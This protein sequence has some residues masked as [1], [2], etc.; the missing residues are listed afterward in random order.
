TNYTRLRV[1]ARFDDGTAVFFNCV[2]ILDD[3]NESIFDAAINL[4]TSQD[5]F[6]RNIRWQ[7]VS[8]QLTVGERQKNYRWKWN[9]ATM[10][11]APLKKEAARRLFNGVVKGESVAVR[12]FGET[13][14]GQPLPAPNP[15]FTEF[16]KSCPALSGS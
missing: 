16:Y 3:S 13:Y 12:V 2:S 8:G 15:D 14:I 5:K 10:I 7:Y 9:P 11:M 6:T 1:E 4:D